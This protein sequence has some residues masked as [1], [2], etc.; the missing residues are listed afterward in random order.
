MGATEMVV[1]FYKGLMMAT[2]AIVD[3]LLRVDCGV[4]ALL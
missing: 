4:I 3:E 1:G 2:I